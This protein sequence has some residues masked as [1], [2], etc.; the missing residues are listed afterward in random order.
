[1]W[2]CEIPI[3]RF[4]TDEQKKRYLPALCDGSLIGVQ[5]MTEPGS[6]S[7]AFSLA[8]SARREGDE[9]I[10]NGSKTFITNAPVAGLFVVFASTD[11]SL[12]FAG[13]SAFLVERGATGLS[14]GR[15][16]HKMGLRTSP[17]SELAFSDCRIP[18]D[19]L[20]GTPGAGMAI[21]NSSME[22]ERSF[23]LAPAVGTMQRLLERCIRYAGERRQFGQSIGKFQSVANKIVDIKIR[24]ETARMMLYRL[25]WLRATGQ[26][27]SLESAMTKLYISEC[28]VQTSL[29]AVQVHGGYGYMT[30]S[31]LEREIRDAIGSRIYSG[32]SE[33]QRAIVARRLG[34]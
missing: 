17:M 1:M 13:V 12:G 24:V 29:D 7:D 18:A 31:E 30:D 16:F 33:I 25:G 9:W 2:S 26:P 8:S 28:L 32:T 19:A 10:L 21:F 15:S 3:L 20:L 22:W 4:G 34:L 27:T 23:I 6:G 14:V 5:G 11:P